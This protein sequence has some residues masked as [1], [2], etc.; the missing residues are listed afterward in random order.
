[1]IYS[2]ISKA[3][4][5]VESTKKR[6]YIEKL[7]KGGLRLGKNVQL[8]DSFFFDPSHCYLI[9]IGDNCIICPNVRIIAHDASTKTILGYTKI[10]QVN[11]KENCFI[12]DSTI[13]LLDVKIGPNSIIGAGSV[14]TK[15]IPPN[16]IA[17]GNPARV[18]SP[19]SE[20]VHKISRMA[21]NKTVFSE[22]YTIDKL[23][24]QK[25]KEIIEATYDSKQF[26]V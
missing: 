9:S 21:G 24:E 26:V 25:L 3:L 6:K 13:I 10:G 17:A 16:V 7:L 2:L 1:M 11:I 22:E 23:D 20:Y 14:V 5:F 18:I 8:I 15:D 12:G 19:L 4:R